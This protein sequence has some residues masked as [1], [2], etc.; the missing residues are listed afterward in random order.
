[1]TD[2]HT[3]AAQD[4][5]DRKLDGF[6]GISMLVQWG[7]ALALAVWLT[8]YTWAGQ[9][10]SLHTH[11]WA[12]GILGGLAAL[13]PFILS[14]VRPGEK[15][16]RLAMA[17]ASVLFT[18][19]FTH[20]AGGRDEAH[21][22][23]FVM[24]AILAIYGDRTVMATAFVT[25]VI[26]HGLRTFLIP[27]SVFGEVSSPLFSLVRHALWAVS[28]TAVCM[29]ACTLT[30]RQRQLVAQSAAD[31]GRRTDDLAETVARIRQ[32]SS[33][34]QAIVAP[35]VEASRQSRT[36]SETAASECVSAQSSARESV[37]T[38][39]DLTE[40]VVAVARSIE[41]ITEASTR[42]QEGAEQLVENA[43]AAAQTAA[44][45][46]ERADAGKRALQELDVAGSEIGRVV[47][48]I[49]EIAEQTNLLALN[50]TI[51]AAR[52]G[53]AGKGFAVVAEEVKELARQSAT[54][55]GDIRARIE[56]MQQSTSRAVDGFLEVH[57]TVVR[58]R[59]FTQQVEQISGA[60]QSSSR[61]IND[62]MRE[63]SS[64]S[65]EMNQ[66]ASTA[67]ERSREVQQ[68]LERFSKTA[69]DAV[70]RA[71][72]THRAA[73]SIGRLVTALGEAVGRED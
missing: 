23:F 61:T 18:T 39:Q 14:R 65:T 42:M 31:Q 59:E 51:E 67:S 38:I 40:R 45:G 52:A 54:A 19:L 7:A 46:A 68:V 53:D 26:D 63:N 34:V 5:I 12:A 30:L 55:A 15:R 1:M 10:M 58:M 71:G 62:Q 11:V 35:L 8:P 29:W 3:L 6:L 73:E 17:I 4:Q 70:Q 2:A 44:T 48:A 21:F 37:S 13:P 28:I 60:Q 47:E 57:D 25:I 41:E 32:T 27:Y 72:D 49:H 22:H 24:F 36:D 69:N 43:S 33:E 9:Q 64:V 66:Q 20:L 56:N 50:A 16:T